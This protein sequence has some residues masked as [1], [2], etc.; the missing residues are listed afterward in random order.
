MPG[1]PPPPRELQ[2]KLRATLDPR[3]LG[4]L[5]REIRTRANV[6]QVELAKKLRIP[7]QNISS[8]EVGDREGMLSTLNRIVRALGWELIL[9]ARPRGSSDAGPSG[10][11][12]ASDE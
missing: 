9:V 5:L 11:S 12:D 8:L 2:M 10:K 7:N 6:T 4:K 1:K 3:D